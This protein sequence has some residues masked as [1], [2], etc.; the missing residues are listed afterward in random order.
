MSQQLSITKAS[1]EIDMKFELFL[2]LVVVLAGCAQATLRS[3]ANV[4]IDFQSHVEKHS[5]GLV[6]GKS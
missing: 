4:D 5:L 1:L 2:V 6:Q 3:A